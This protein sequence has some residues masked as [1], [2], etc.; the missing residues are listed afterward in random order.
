MTVAKP[1]EDSPE[2]VEQLERLMA[3][4]ML[5]SRETPGNGASWAAHDQPGASWG[6]SLPDN[7]RR[8][9]SPIAPLATTFGNKFFVPSPGLL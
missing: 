9:T 6:V 5:K 1:A 4:A 2:S 3:A 7:V 8:I